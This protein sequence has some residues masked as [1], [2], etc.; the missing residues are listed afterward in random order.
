MPG[1]PLLCLRLV[2]GPLGADIAAPELAGTLQVG[3]RQ[4]ELG[5]GLGQLRPLD[6]SVELDHHLAGR[7][8]RPSSKFIRAIRPAISGRSTTDPLEI[9][10]ADGLRAQLGG[11]YLDLGGLN[12]NLDRAHHRCGRLCHLPAATAPPFSAGSM[13]NFQ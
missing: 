6:R 7:D 12:R 13:T 5:L 8:L 2:Q 10:A 4:L 11:R 1:F 9:D 3:G